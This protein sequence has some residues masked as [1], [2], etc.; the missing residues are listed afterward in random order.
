MVFTNGGSVGR[1]RDYLFKGNGWNERCVYKLWYDPVLLK[2][3]ASGS[4]TNDGGEDISSFST[5]V[6]EPIAALKQVSDDMNAALAKVISKRQ[7]QFRDE[8][9]Q[10]KRKMLEP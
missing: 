10:A 8:I 7:G 1:R 9:E 6:G 5:F 3:R 4:T 2:W